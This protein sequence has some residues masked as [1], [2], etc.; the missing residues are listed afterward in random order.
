MRTPGRPRTTALAA[1]AL[2]LAGCAGGDPDEDI[3]PPDPATAT[4]GATPD[5]GA[6]EGT[7][8]AGGTPAATPAGTP[9]AAPAPAAAP[10]AD[11]EVRVEAVV[12]EGLDAPWGLAPLPGGDVLVS[13]RDEGDVVRVSPDGSV[14]AVGAVPGVEHGGEGGLLGIA[15]SPGFARDRLLY[16]YHTA[17]D[18]NR[19]VRMTYDGRGLGEPEVVLDGIAAGSTH[20]GGR[21]VFAPDGT[22]LVG[23]GDAGDRSSSQ[24]PSSLN[25]K[26]LRVTPDG[27]P[28][29]GNPDPSSPVLTSG[30]RNVQ[31]I[32]VDGRG[33]LWAAEFG[34][35]TWDEL[36]RLRP[37]GDHGWPEVEGRAG[38]DGYVDPVVQ[39]RPEDASPSGIAVAGGAVYV[40][41]LRGERLWQVPLQGGEPRAWLEGELGRLRTVEPTA[42]GRGLWLLTSDTDGRGDVDDGDDRLLRLSLV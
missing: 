2:L 25:G 8:A 33:G 31:G 19:V 23:T 15:L 30:H 14:R 3:G 35:D 41:G 1:A 36:N 42:D 5:G 12:A 40:A 7:P 17:E 10:P 29:P 37:G 21:I 28:A 20:N 22:L 26:V 34:Q 18:G 39:W 38:E 27:A 9:A 13:Q 4:V 16:A 32:A 24:D 11:A 6:G